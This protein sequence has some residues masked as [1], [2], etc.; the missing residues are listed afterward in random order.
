MAPG[1]LGFDPSQYLCPTA[2]AQAVTLLLDQVTLLKQKLDEVTVEHRF[3]GVHQA[4]R[5]KPAAA[6]CQGWR[7]PCRNTRQPFGSLVRQNF[8]TLAWGA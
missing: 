1:R 4:A 3:D 8:G 6:N 2:A 7:A 5:R